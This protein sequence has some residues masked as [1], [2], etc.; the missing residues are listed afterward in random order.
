MIRVLLHDTGKSVSLLSQ[1]HVKKTLKYVD[2]AL[3]INPNN[4]A[5]TSGLTVMRLQTP[6]VASGDYVAPLDDLSAAR[7]KPPKQFDAWWN[8]PVLKDAEATIFSRRKLVL[9][10]A[11]TDGGAHVDP[12]LNA[13]YEAL[14]RQNSFGW[15]MVANDDV[16]PFANSPVLPSIRQ[17]AHELDRTLTTSLGTWL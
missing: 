5:P 11:N 13:A 1:L 14:A 6:P 16:Q 15:I 9:E 17:I 3:E 4:L 7:R 10:A 8:D 12:S 2:T